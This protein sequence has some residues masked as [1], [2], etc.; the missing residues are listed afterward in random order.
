MKK[1]E[2]NIP[3]YEKQSLENVKKLKLKQHYSSNG[4]YTVKCEKWL[5]KNF[6]VKHA[7]LT[8][9]CTSALEMIALLIN[10]KKGDE[11]IVPSYTFV[12]T[13][14]AFTNY[15]ASPVF[16]DIDPKTMNIDPNKITKLITKKTK[17]IIIVH[18][19]GISCELEKIKKIA[20]KKNLILVEDNAH[21]FL[22]KYKNKYLGS[23]GDFATLSFH[24]SKN[25]HCGEGG[26]LLINNPKYVERAKIIR[27]KGTNREKFNK[28]IVKKYTWVDVGSS[29]AISEINASFLFEQL[30]KSKFINKIRM[31]IWKYYDNY[32]KKLE[33]EKK[34]IRPFVPKYSDHN[35]HIYYIHIQKKNRENLIK[36]LKNR[37]ISAFFHYVPLHN[38]P[39]GLKISNKTKHL[40]YTDIKSKTLLRLPLH[41]SLNIN[42]VKHILKNLT[43][44][45]S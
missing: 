44:F 30:K 28:N 12:S 4:Y 27:D 2:F 36:N 10:I 22:A 17:A 21:G 6:K 33:Y 32:L 14:N 13:A 18:Y 45:L 20:S 8:H 25:V 39:F 41:T 5:K 3:H 34:I 38:S 15:G 26:A 40:K 23:F 35:A 37:N 24:E 29:F 19:A 11:I 42:Q 43:K 31:R 1:I 7:I 9:S 16:A